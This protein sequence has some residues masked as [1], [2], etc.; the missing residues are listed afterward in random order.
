VLC[1]NEKMTGPDDV[2]TLVVGVRY[3]DERG[4]CFEPSR[5]VVECAT[6]ESDAS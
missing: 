2:G 1:V 4:F 6:S 3:V 5:A